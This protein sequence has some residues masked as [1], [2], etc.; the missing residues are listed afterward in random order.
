MKKLGV[1]ETSENSKENCE[2]ELN[3]GKHHR[4]FLSIFLLG[5]SWGY[6]SILL[7]VNLVTCLFRSFPNFLE[8]ST[9]NSAS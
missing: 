2:V 8:D 4:A 9:F 3:E 1:T 6:L 5:L 7:K